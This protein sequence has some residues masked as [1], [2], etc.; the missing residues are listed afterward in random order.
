MENHLYLSDGFSNCTYAEFCLGKY[1]SQRLG[2]ALNKPAKLFWSTQRQ[3]S[4]AVVASLSPN[5]SSRDHS[6]GIKTS[7]TTKQLVFMNFMQFLKENSIFIAF[8]FS[9]HLEQKLHV[10][11][12]TFVTKGQ[13]FSGCIV[14]TLF[15]HEEQFW[16]TLNFS[17]KRLPDCSQPAK[18]S[19]S[20]A[21][22]L[23]K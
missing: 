7:S 20:A 8:P 5:T 12:K 6:E 21:Q 4:P 17:A 14:Y 2:T 3:A 22:I 1:G 9:S 19:K 23:F 11:V 13:R 15:A 18:V 16:T 10:M